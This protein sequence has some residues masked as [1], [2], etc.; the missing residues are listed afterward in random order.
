MLRIRKDGWVYECVDSSDNKSP[1]F[2]LGQV[3][4]KTKKPLICLGVNPST[5]I[6]DDLDK[7]LTRVKNISSKNEGEFDGWIM[8]NLY[9]QRATNPKEIDTEKNFKIDLHYQN[10]EN[11]KQVFASYS[12][13]KVWA[14]WGGPIRTRVFL[15]SKCLND[16]A[17]L[18][19]Q[20]SVVW[21]MNGEATLLGDPR[22]PSR[23]KNGLP[24]NRFDIDEYLNDV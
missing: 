10:L 7:T 24:F 16:I 13:L 19:K 3:S 6:P 18:G 23:L 14:A 1:R 17:T 4:E 20:Y 2:V 12:D 21:R 5:A 9:P 22:H 8:I 11:I 15:K